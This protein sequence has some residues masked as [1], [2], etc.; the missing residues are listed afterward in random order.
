MGLLTSDI[1]LRKTAI[2]NWG[3][4]IHNPDSQQK[5]L[6]VRGH[7]TTRDFFSM[8]EHEFIYGA[9]WNAIA[10]EHF[11]NVIVISE[12]INQKL[13][14]G[15]NSVGKSIVYESN[16]YQVVGVIKRKPRTNPTRTEILAAIPLMVKYFIQPKCRAS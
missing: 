11:Q 8:F 9:P 2:T 5:A 15:G 12:D 13:F 4:A 6:F 1:P 7:I 10:D 14:G 3:G 16:Q